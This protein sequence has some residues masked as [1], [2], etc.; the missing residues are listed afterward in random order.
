MHDYI[1]CLRF[2]VKLKTVSTVI[3]VKQEY[4]LHD[5]NIEDFSTPVF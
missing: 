5:I 4:A 1:T 2:V 3:L